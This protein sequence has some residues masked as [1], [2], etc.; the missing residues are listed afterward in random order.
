MFSRMYKHYS[1]IGTEREF[2]FMTFRRIDVRL[3]DKSKKTH[4]TFFVQNFLGYKLYNSYFCRETYISLSAH[5][6]TNEFKIKKLTLRIQP[7]K[8]S[9]TGD[10]L[11]KILR[12]NIQEWGLN[13]PHIR[14]YFV[15]D[16]AAHIV[17]AV[18]LCSEWERIP[19]FAHTLQV[20]EP[21]IFN[22]KS[23]TNIQQ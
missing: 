11:N 15:T 2:H 5:Y 19:C 14:I 21:K 4:R 13:K 12:K 16:D 7:Y 9:H 8:E 1:F 18:E 20:N 23:S 17:Q 6:V 3:F 10:N 22:N